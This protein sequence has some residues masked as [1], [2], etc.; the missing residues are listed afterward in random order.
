MTFFEPL[1][2]Q[3]VQNLEQKNYGKTILSLKKKIIH[4]PNDSGFAYLVRGQTGLSML[5]SRIKNG[6]QLSH[7]D[8]HQTLQD[9]SSA[10]ELA[11]ELAKEAF[12]QKGIVYSLIESYTDA[13]QDFGMAEKLGHPDAQEKIDAII[14][15]YS[16]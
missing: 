11:P 7:D 6:V 8:C 2:N 3:G 4:Y 14:S 9:Y 16:A 12:Y 15:L 10:I 5:V 1:L 13:L